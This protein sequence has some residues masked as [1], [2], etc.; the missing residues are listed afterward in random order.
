MGE[1]EARRGEFPSRAGLPRVVESRQGLIHD[2]SFRSS[3]EWENEDGRHQAHE[4]AGA[5]P[6]QGRLVVGQFGFAGTCSAR[7][8]RPSKP[9][10]F[11]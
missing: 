11:E 1:R 6:G 5:P 4:V 7:D 8:K 2:G 3:R 10:S 9:T